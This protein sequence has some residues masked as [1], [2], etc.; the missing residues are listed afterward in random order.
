MET[1]PR[2]KGTVLNARKNFV[3]KHFGEEGWQR[4]HAALDA[5]DRHALAVVMPVGWYPFA[6][7]ER[8]DRAIVDV[9][10]GGDTAVFEEL[11]VASARENLGGAHRF[12]LK[13]GKPQAFL[14]RTESIYAL[15]YDHGRRT[16]EPTG[17]CSGV[18]T[19]YD[20]DTYSTA[21][22]L[23]VVGWHKEALAM[24]GARDVKVEEE[25]CRAHGGPCCRYRVEWRMDEGA[26][27]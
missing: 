5:D 27:S 9:L 25:S 7:G 12:F 19:T 13:P 11:G 20:A 23:T 6:L 3:V 1:A 17:P 2:I 14:S 26:A 22:C 18:L 24:C 8:L 10:G 21:D 15:Y 4:V 16:Y